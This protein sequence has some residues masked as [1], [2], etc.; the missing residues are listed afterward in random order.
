[1]RRLIEV[2]VVITSQLGI[3]AAVIVTGIGLK[4]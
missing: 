4:W 3:P 1:M 2:L